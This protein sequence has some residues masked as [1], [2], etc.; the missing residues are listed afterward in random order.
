M[1]KIAKLTLL[2]KVGK[3]CM[4]QANIC[5]LMAN[6]NKHWAKAK[7]MGMASNYKVLCTTLSK[8]QDSM[9]TQM[10]HKASNLK[11]TLANLTNRQVINEEAYHQENHISSYCPKKTHKDAPAK[12]HVSNQTPT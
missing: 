5:K 10:D 12:A 2:N 7:S 9:T 6:I 3:I 11:S 1:D 8:H 4:F